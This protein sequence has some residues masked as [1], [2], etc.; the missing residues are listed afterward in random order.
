[1]N[2]Q[3]GFHDAG[4][5]D[6][7]QDAAAAFRR[8]AEHLSAL[9]AQNPPRP[10]HDLPRIM[11]DID[12][13]LTK[14]AQTELVV[15]PPLM[16]QHLDLVQG[17]LAGLHDN[18]HPA[19]GADLQAR[20]AASTFTTTLDPALGCMA[21]YCSFSLSPK[22]PGFINTITFGK[23]AAKDPFKLFNAYVHESLHGLQKKSCAALHAS[24]FN[25]SPLQIKTTGADG[26][27]REENVSVIICPDDWIVLDEHCE[28]DAYAKEAWLNSLLADHMPEAL[29]AGAGG[30]GGGAAEF[31]RCRNL[32]GNLEGGLRLYAEKA[33]MTKFWVKKDGSPSDTPYCFAHNWQDIALAHYRNAIDIRQREGKDN[34]IFVRACAADI[35]DISRSFGPVIFSP[36][37]SGPL[38][39]TPPLT[40]H[41][42]IPIEFSGATAKRLK[43]LNDSLGIDDKNTLP[44]L[45]EFLARHNI[46]PEA[47]MQRTVRPAAVFTPP[48]ASPAP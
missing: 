41:H 35:E 40:T 39:G 26:V 1:M 22:N 18:E 37:P 4:G 13:A 20:I 38:Q 7:L 3:Q 19:T 17:W 9:L 14:G 8:A 36:A 28:Q 16:Q 2:P 27:E 23:L 29:H 48:P 12:A 10:E 47:F 45:R 42:G 6:D 21:T 33:A 11:E 24:P 5:N 15:L 46:T 32:A 34:F 30:P 31:R 43:K 25:E 44:T